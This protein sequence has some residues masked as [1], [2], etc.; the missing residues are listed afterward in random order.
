MSV[1]GTQPTRRRAAKRFS[2]LRKDRPMAD[3]VNG[4][5]LDEFATFKIGGREIKVSALTLWDLEQS[6]SDIQGMT[7]DTVWT[8]YAAKVVR[9]IARKTSPEAWESLAEQMMKACSAGEARN[10]AAQFNDLWRVSG[11]MGEAEA[12]QEATSGTG[13]STESPPN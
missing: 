1:A 9:I 3:E 5:S 4:N 7:P 8:E 10:L 2:N 6:R 11:L 12:V 13:T